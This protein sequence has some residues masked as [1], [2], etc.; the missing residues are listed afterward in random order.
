[1]HSL[2]TIEKE[3]ARAVAIAKEEARLAGL[4]ALDVKT[5]GL[6]L[7]EFN[8]EYSFYQ[9][10]RVVIVAGSYLEALNFLTE[11]DKSAEYFTLSDVTPVKLGARLDFS[12]S[13]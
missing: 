11:A 13:E 3:N 10:D 1:M 2:S 8:T 9:L 12:Y 7:Y 5:T 4:L 6:K